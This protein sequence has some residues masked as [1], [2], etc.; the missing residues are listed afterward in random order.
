MQ[1]YRRLFDDLWFFVLLCCCGV[2]LPD[3]WKCSAHMYY[4]C[5][6]ENKKNL[7]DIA[8][9]S[10]TFD[11]YYYHAKSVGATRGIALYSAE[12]LKDV[13]N[14]M[15]FPWCLCFASDKIQSVL[16]TDTRASIFRCWFERGICLYGASERNWFFYCFFLFEPNPVRFLKTSLLYLL[17]TWNIFFSRSSALHQSPE[18]HIWQIL[19][20]SSTYLL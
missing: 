18:L 5:V 1:V 13:D 7:F 14:S 10:R 9:T 17:A 3:R 20:C 12:P 15:P 16:H 2:P 4:V 19:P 11:Y 8:F 6:W